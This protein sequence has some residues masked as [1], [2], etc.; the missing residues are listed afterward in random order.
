MTLSAFVI[1]EPFMYTDLY[2][3]PE[4]LPRT[5]VFNMYN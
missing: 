3:S 1:Y 4:L 5:Q 2:L